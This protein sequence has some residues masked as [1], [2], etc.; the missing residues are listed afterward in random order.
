[1]ESKKRDVTFILTTTLLLFRLCNCSDID[2][3]IDISPGRQECFWE[4]LPS[5][6]SVEV[7]YQVIDG[8]DLD[9]DV[10]VVGPDNRIYQMDQRKTENTMRIETGDAGDYK[11]CF[12]N[13]FSRISN[14]LVFFEIFIEDGKDDE[15]DDDNTLTF[16]GENMQGQLDMTVEEFKGILER[17]KKNLDRS[18]Q[19]QTLIKLHEAK[20]R[21]TQEAN[22]FR[23]N[24]FSLFQLVL[25]IFVGLVQVI[26]IRSLFT[27]QQP[28]SGGSLKART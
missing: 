23:V 20:D 8:G 13:T 25:M 1:M 7:D 27:Y 12:D 10:M 9:I 6:T 5:K 18:I 28:A 26:V 19:V 11:V 4:T 24:F 17:A 3:T 15:D 16:E 22:F 21:N 2:L 14:K